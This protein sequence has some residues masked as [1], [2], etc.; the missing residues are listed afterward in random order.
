MSGRR[1]ALQ[2]DLFTY[3]GDLFVWASEVERAMW[4]KATH[5]SVPMQPGE[6]TPLLLLAEA[7]LKVAREYNDPDMELN[8][9]RLLGR[10]P[11]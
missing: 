5:S 6:L 4:S 1:S 2:F 7:V 3:Q 10:K 11:H 9:M 8:A